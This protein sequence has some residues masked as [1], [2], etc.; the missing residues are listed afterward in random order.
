MNSTYREL[1]RTM[2]HRYLLWIVSLISI[3][4]YFVLSTEVEITIHPLTEIVADI[5]ANGGIYKAI[6]EN[7]IVT[8]HGEVL[9]VQNL[10]GTS[11]EAT[12]NFR[13]DDIHP[14]KLPSEVHV[15]ATAHA[16]RS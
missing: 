12:L 10:N 14:Y 4:G 13:P 3:S 7:M 11:S 9:S 2:E 16:E 5:L 8:S 15:I 1:L 6:S